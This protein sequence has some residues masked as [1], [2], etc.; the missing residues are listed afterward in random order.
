MPKKLFILFQYVLPQLLLTRFAGWMADCPWVFLKNWLIKD[1]IRRYHVDL[2]SAVLEKVAD[3]P[4]FNAF[5]TRALKKN[6]R[7]ISA[8][9][10][11]L[12]NPV[13]GYLSQIGNL[14]KNKLLQAK[15]SDYSL[16]TLLGIAEEEVSPFE[17]GQF[18]T[19]YLSPKD[20]HRVHLPYAATLVQ[21]TYIP[22]KLF[23]V[24]FLAAEKIP[25]LFARNER[26]VC[27]F[28]T[29]L[30]PMAV[31]FIGAMI[32][33]KIETAWG[34]IERSKS[35]VHRHYDQHEKLYFEKGAELGRFL[36]G[37]S[38]ILLFGKNKIK[39]LPHLQEKMQITMGQPLG[40]A[41]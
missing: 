16:K 25:S 4:T 3:Y 2:S 32:V 28:E 8:E 39:W 11:I 34:L 14:D 15:G 10:N 18:A 1:F 6:A 22:G 19:F 30:G 21:S 37:S 41:F 35:I 17:G 5:F 9:K 27:L 38:V 40:V 33:G 13:D 7:P 24:N 23:S 36:L 12:V 29:E 26:L 31:I 20:Y